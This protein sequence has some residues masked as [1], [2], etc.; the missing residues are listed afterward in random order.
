MFAVSQASH[1]DDLDAQ[2]VERLPAL[3]TTLAEHFDYVLVD[4]IRDLGDYALAV[5][6]MTDDIVLVLTQDVPAVR[7]ASV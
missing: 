3:M 1:L 6:D 7:R 4:G 2:L 5:L